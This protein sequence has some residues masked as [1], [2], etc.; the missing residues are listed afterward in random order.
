MSR[1]STQLKNLVLAGVVAF[2]A[3]VAMS[4]DSF[5]ADSSRLA[6]APRRGRE[7]ATRGRQAPATHSQPQTDAQAV[8]TSV[9]AVVGD[10]TVRVD[11]GNSASRSLSLP[12]GKSAVIEL[13]VDARDVV[14]SD[15]KVAEVV[16]STPR[17]IYVLG[18]AAGQTDAVFFDSAGRQLLRLDVRVDQDVSAL[19]QTLNRLLPG[20]QIKI[21]AVNDRVIL[22][23]QVTDASAADKAVRVAESYVSKPDNILNMLSINGREQVMVKVKVI[24]VNRTVIK[25][26]GFNL[27]EVLGQAGMN[28]YTFGIA[29][30]YGVNGSLLG[31]VTGG[32]AIDTTKQPL[33]TQLC[34]SA[35]QPVGAIC[36]VVVHGTGAVSN[37]DTASVTSNLAGKT[38]VNSAKAMIQAFERVGLVRTLAE[39]NL[40]ALSGESAHFL[41]GG[42]FPVPVGQDSTGRVSVEFK[43]Y[44]VGLGFTPVVLGQ[45]RISLKVSTE[46]SEL[47]NSGGFTLTT[48]SSST[49]AIPGLTV[50]RVETTV[51][52]PSGGAIMLAGLMQNTT[53]QNLDSLP[54]LQQL[55]VLGS[56]FRSRDFLNNESELV[57]IITPYLVKATSPDQLASPADGLVIA[58]DL[59]TNLLGRLNHSFG[60]PE[61]ATAGKS[62]KGPFGYVVE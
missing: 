44:G 11:I 59:E 36:N 17:R 57:V 41:A 43:Q 18:Q 26:L 31:G 45:G 21:E 34:N 52:L 7:A 40:T 23:G 35:S 3:T 53:K 62:Y 50:R 20:S 28:Q 13:P 46:V 2:A 55:P 54:G 58:N 32:Y 48:G 12:K 30:T 56:L 4:A 9:Q 51:E 49:L 39:P 42:E 47:S 27:N 38:G 5:A 60:R 29:P 61:T 22:T 10:Q 19:A 25:Q 14:V 37:G 16:L 24:E 15:P 1:T 8:S 6:G 33:M